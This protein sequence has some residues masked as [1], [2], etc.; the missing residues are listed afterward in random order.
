MKVEQQ[1]NTQT[2]EASWSND[3]QSILAPPDL[4]N[5]VGP[6]LESTGLSRSRYSRRRRRWASR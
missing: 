4:S 5:P 3:L 1:V 2:S 6:C